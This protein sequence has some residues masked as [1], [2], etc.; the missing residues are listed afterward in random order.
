[1]LRKELDSIK[2]KK[3]IQAS[4]W[5]KYEASVKWLEG[6]GVEIVKYAVGDV[7]V[8]IPLE[9]R[10]LSFPDVKGF[11]DWVKNEIIYLKPAEPKK[12]LITGD[13]HY[14][15]NL[16]K[17][18]LLP[19]SQSICYAGL[20][21]LLPTGSMEDIRPKGAPFSLKQGGNMIHGINVSTLVALASKDSDLDLI[22]GTEGLEAEI[23]THLLEQIQEEKT[24]RAKEAARHILA[25]IKRADHCINLAVESIRA[26][27]KQEKAD[28]DY[29]EKVK[30]AKAYG[31]ETNNF[32]PLLA[33]IE[34]ISVSHVSADLKKIPEGW[35]PK[36][37]P[38]G[39]YPKTV[40]AAS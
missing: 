4:D 20:D 16:C 9:G 8:N 15:Q 39:E 28:K 7:Y 23:R 36:E 30:H 37:Q 14:G 26:A 29:I 5:V 3:F 40:D 38:Q 34:P 27:R 2:F 32:I 22:N 25:S 31:L 11:V 33:L 12:L 10:S 6:M 35:T 1:M 13:F 24:G 17:E 21:S 19:G 18:I